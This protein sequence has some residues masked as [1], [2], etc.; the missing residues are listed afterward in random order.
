MAHNGAFLAVSPGCDL[1]TYDYDLIIDEKNKKKVKVDERAIFLNAVETGLGD[2]EVGIRINNTKYMIT[3]YDKDKK[4]IYLS[5]EKGGACI[6]KT[7]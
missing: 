4:L 1:K 5:K 3:M 7:K 6:Y 2:K